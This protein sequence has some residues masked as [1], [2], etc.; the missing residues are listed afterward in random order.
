G[1]FFFFSSRR[2]HTR[3]KRDWSSDV[4]SSDLRIGPAPNIATIYPASS[5]PEDILAA[6]TY[7]A[8]RNW[9][10]LDVAVHGHYNATAWAYLEERGYTPIMEGDDMDI[11][12]QGKP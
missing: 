12:Q 10:Y 4:C 6:D 1:C 8:I 7:A 9:L 2:R 3:S 5:K 11:L